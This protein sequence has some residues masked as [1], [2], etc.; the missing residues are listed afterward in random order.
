MIENDYIAFTTGDR[1][2]LTVLFSVDG[3][4]LRVT[5]ARLGSHSDVPHSPHPAVRMRTPTSKA[6]V[7]SVARLLHTQLS[8]HRPP[9][10]DDLEHVLPRAVEAVN[11]QLALRQAS[12]NR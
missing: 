9:T 12:G 6:I 1:Q 4:P 10:R 5:T 7:E 2:Q 8:K 3:D 11:Q